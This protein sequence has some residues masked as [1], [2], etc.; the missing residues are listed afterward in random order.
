MAAIILDFEKSF[1]KV[2]HNGLLH[3]MLKLNTPPQI[4][5]IIRFFLDNRS[6]LVQKED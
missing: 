6:F 1:D 4:V 2:S 5:E 3:K